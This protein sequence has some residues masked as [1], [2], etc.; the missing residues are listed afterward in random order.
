MRRFLN[1]LLRDFKTT[2]SASGGRG[3]PR[4]AMP[5][6]EGLEDRLVLSTARQV[7]STL[8]VNVTPGLVGGPSPPGHPRPAHFRKVSFQVDQANPAK[9]DVLDAGKLLD[10]FTIASIKNVDIKV[11]GLDKVKVDDSLGLPFA[12]GTIVT[13]SGSGPRNSLNLF[14]SRTITG[15]ETYIAGNDAKDGSLT[16]GDVTFDFSSTIRSLTDSVKTTGPLVVEGFRQNVSLDCSSDLTQTL[17]GLSVGGA[18]DRLKY[19]NKAVVDVELFSAK[20]LHPDARPTS[21]ITIEDSSQKG[22]AVTVNL[23][24]D[25]G[26]ALDLV[27]HVSPLR[28]PA[29]LTI[30]AP[31]GEFSQVPPKTPKGQ[32]DVKFAGGL[33]SEVNYD[34]FTSVTP[35]LGAKG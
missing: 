15:G 28:A 35:L 24:R 29:S 23:N 13:L 3:A 1:K 21:Q 12:S 14:G 4:S 34:G 2:T 17:S 11:A 9:L 31:D 22:L 10:Q 18:G 33:A 7:G 8:L 25:S 20:A 19:S 27:N 16:L 26:L 6:V 30:F 32:E 5:Q